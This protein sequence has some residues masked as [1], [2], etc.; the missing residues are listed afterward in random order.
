MDLRTFFSQY[1]CERHLHPSPQSNLTNWIQK[2][3]KRLFS[4][5]CL[6]CILN[7]VTSGSRKQDVSHYVK[8]V[9]TILHK[10]VGDITVVTSSIYCTVFDASWHTSSG[11]LL[12]DL[13]LLILDWTSV[14]VPTLDYSSEAII[15]VIKCTNLIIEALSSS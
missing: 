7:T 15:F 9:A 2:C 4:S 5:H 14:S 13:S 1:N 11:L 8:C 3:S 12:A 6:K 10:P